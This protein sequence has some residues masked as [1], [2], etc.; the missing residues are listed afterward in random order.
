MMLQELTTNKALANRIGYDVTILGR[1]R[2]L[3]DHF[4]ALRA[5][6]AADVQRVAQTYLIDEGTSI[7]HVVPPAV[8]LE[9][10]PV[11]SELGGS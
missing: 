6:T 7:V 1:I 2:P 5:V 4:A 3:E 8:A 9:S 11:A 10:D